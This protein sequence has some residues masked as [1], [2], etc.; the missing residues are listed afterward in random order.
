MRWRLTMKAWAYVRP[1]LCSDSHLLA[2]RCSDDRV[3]AAASLNP[4]LARLH[5]LEASLD[6]FLVH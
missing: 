6:R 3:L 1:T 5:D 2:R 4:V